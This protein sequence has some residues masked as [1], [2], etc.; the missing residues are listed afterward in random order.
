MGIVEGK[1]SDVSAETVRW[2]AEWLGVDL[3]DVRW[4]RRRDA[5]GLARR[6]L[7]VWLAH[8]D[9]VSTRDLSRVLGIHK[10][11]VINIRRALELVGPR[12]AAAV[13]RRAAV[14]VAGVPA[15]LDEAAVVELHE[16]MLAR[17]KAGA[18]SKRPGRARP[19][20]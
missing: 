19:R 7:L 18:R 11:A 17:A 8:V 16:R 20:R 1:A 10:D 5:V 9:G 3:A 2:Y 4:R 6:A 14:R 15:A 12:S 13:K